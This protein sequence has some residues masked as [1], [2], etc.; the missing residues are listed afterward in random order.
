[1]K[2]LFKKRNDLSL[3]LSYSDTKDTDSFSI[4]MRENLWNLSAYTFAKEN[5]SQNFGC[6]LR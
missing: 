4:Q 5:L 6:I 3:C 2:T 1:M